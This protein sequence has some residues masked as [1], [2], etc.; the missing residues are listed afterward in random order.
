MTCRRAS[1]PRSGRPWA[2]TPCIPS[3]PACCC[4][5]GSTSSSCWD[6]GSAETHRIFRSHSLRLHIFCLPGIQA[7]LKETGHTDLT[8][9]LPS[10]WDSGSA[11]THRTFR[12]HSHSQAPRLPSCWDSG[13]AETK[14]FFLTQISDKT[15]R[16]SQFGYSE[17]LIPTERQGTWWINW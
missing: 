1:R 3:C 8:L 9:S 10:C 4:R 6:S 12:S 7:L 5:P 13:S 15:V 14:D 16:K 17:L 2:P 11:E